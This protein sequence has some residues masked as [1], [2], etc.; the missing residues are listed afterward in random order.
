MNKVCV[1]AKNFETYFIKRLTEEVGGDRITHFNPWGVQIQTLN[2]KYILMRTSG[3][4]GDD[5]DLEVL[6]DLRNKSKIINPIEAM[7]LYRSKSF[8]YSYFQRM[9]VPTLPWV[10][11]RNADD[12]PFEFSHVIAKP[13]RGQGGWGIKIMEQKDFPLW[14][15]SQITKEDTSYVVQPYLEADYE[16]RV[17]FIG[18]QLFAVKREAAEVGPVNFRLGGSAEP[19]ALTKNQFKLVQKW[20]KLSGADYG[21]WDILVKGKALYVLELNV[22]PGIEQIEEVLDL[23]IMKIFIKTLLPEL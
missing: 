11:L 18:D 20:I 4:Y 3:V 10:K 13:S 6:D 22:T 12:R 8:Q 9:G 2:G 15:D 17:F 23:N 7:S 16:I 1:V 14:R 21:A 19:F 5:R